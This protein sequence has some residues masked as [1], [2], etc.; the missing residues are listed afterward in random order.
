M[1]GAYLC[2]DLICRDVYERDRAIKFITDPELVRVRWVY[3]HSGHLCML[4]K[5]RC[6]EQGA[7]A[8]RAKELGC[9]CCSHDVGAVQQAQQPNEC[10]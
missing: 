3:C 2:E 8:E 7:K 6:D 10:Y 9:E 4:G 1:P 5:A